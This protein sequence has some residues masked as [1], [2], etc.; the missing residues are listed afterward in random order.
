VV[1][2]GTVIKER[3]SPGFPFAGDEFFRDFFPE[4][5][6]REY[7]RTSLGSG[8]VVDGEKGHIITNHHVVSRAA[9]IKVTTA[10]Q[11]EYEARILGSDPRSDLALLEIDAGRE[12]PEIPMGDSEDLMIGETVIAIGNPFGLSHTVTT[13]V[14]SAVDRTVRSGGA[15]YR[16]FIQTDASINPGNSG[17]PLLNIR[18]DLIG[19]NTAIYQK[20]QG[21]GFAIPV[22]KAKRIIEELIRTGEVRFPWLGVELQELTDELKRHFGLPI[23]DQGVLVRDLFRGSPAQRAGIKR[24][25]IIQALGGDRINSL[26]DY[27]GVLSEYAPGNSVDLRLFRDGEVGKIRVRLEAFPVDLALDLVERRTGLEV[28]E[29]GPSLRRRYGLEKAVAIKEVKP[30]TEADEAGL[31][32]GDLI[33]KINKKETPDLEAFKRAVSRYHQ[34]PSLTLFVRRGAYVYSLTLP[35]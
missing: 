22:N 29:A 18:G 10:D 33:L 17:G 9:E 8:V 31:E 7:T 14:V 3:F 6:G 1:N 5:F 20:A 26:S 2:V 32:P 4:L 12:L 21:I 25:D 28:A 34:L 24:G 16:N 30:G 11:E 23:E 27:R 15:V 13:G 35:F 19:I